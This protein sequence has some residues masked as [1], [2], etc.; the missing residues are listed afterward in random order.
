[1]CRATTSSR[2]AAA[3]ARQQYLQRLGVVGPCGSTNNSGNSGIAG[4]LK[5]PPAPFPSSDGAHHQ[6]GSD[7]SCRGNDDA[8]CASGNSHS[9]K[10]CRKDGR[11]SRTRR[12]RIIARHD[13]HDHSGDPRPEDENNDDVDDAYAAATRRATAGSSSFPVKLYEV[14]MLPAASS[15]NRVY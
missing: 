6:M 12:P 13:Y 7:G 14:S 11:S 3:A 4:A 10:G 5:F 8:S 1:M 15:K 9:N 2:S